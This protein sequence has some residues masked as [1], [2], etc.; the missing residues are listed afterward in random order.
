[1]WSRLAPLPALAV[2]AVIA[3]R[4]GAP[5]S[6][7]AP[8]L[9]GLAGGLAGYF[10]ARRVRAEALAAW[11]P[12]LAAAAI[13]ATLLAPDLEGVRRW[14]ALG[15][16][17]VNVSAALAPWLLL[18]HD[19]PRSAVRGRAAAA[20]LVAQVAHLAQP[21]AGQAT[22]LAVGIALSTRERALSA[23]VALLAAATWLRPDPLA[24]VA[25][26][27]RVLALAAAQ[28][29]PSVAAAAL[30]VAALLVPLRARPAAAAY[31]LAAL[32]VPLVGHFPVPVLGAGAGPVLGWYALRV[33]AASRSSPG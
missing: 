13:C 27:E 26:V 12:A 15:P 32:I 30:A 29:A 3:H 2:G 20:V 28:G 19:A 8:S 33:T 21:D 11:M 16:L 5:W 24:P 1:V 14:I 7:F 17:R 18:G 9:I 6:V 25:H 4:S 10:A 31:L 23:G 22:A